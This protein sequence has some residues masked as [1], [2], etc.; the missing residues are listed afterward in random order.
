VI[1]QTDVR[2]NAETWKEDNADAYQA[3]SARRAPHE[4]ATISRPWKGVFAGPMGKLAVAAAIAIVG[5]L[6]A[7]TLRPEK[8]RPTS[9]PPDTPV[10]DITTFK[11]LTLAYRRGGEEALNRQLDTAQEALGPRPDSSLLSDLLDDLR[12]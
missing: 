9:S 4:H 7:L 1:G 5:T 8:N 10:S 3:L 2:F 12:G 6:A 11:S